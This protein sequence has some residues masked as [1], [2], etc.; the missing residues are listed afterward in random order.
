MIR[1]VQISFHAGSRMCNMHRYLYPH[2][3][4]YIY[5]YSLRWTTTTAARCSVPS[6]T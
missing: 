1:L 4:I 3:C 6:S 2:I 5:P